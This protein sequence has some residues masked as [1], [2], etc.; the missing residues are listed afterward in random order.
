MLTTVL[1]P[2]MRAMDGPA[3]ARFMHGFLPIARR[4][5]SNHV[6]VAGMGA[7]SAIAVVLLRDRAGEAASTLTAIGFAACM[8][9]PLLVSRHWVEPNYDVIMAWDH[10]DALPGSWTATRARYFALNWVRAE[11]TW[12]AF[13][14]LL[15][16]LVLQLGTR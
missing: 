6:A 7:A 9:G 12:T 10:P 13:A 16:A 3:W 4:A 2:V 8:A 15:A 14:A 5:P 11:A 1:H